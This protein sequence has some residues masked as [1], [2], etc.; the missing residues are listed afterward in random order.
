M[1]ISA[2]AIL[3][4]GTTCLGVILLI[5]CV[6]CLTIQRCSENPGPPP[7]A[8]PRHRFTR[9]PASHI[10]QAY[11]ASMIAVDGADVGDT[12]AICLGELCEDVEG[13]LDRAK[14][15]RVGLDSVVIEDGSGTS[16]A[17]PGA[18]DASPI[19]CASSTGVRN[20]IKGVQPADDPAAVV[21]G[22]GPRRG[23][24]AQPLHFFRGAHS[25]TSG[26]HAPP[27]L[28]RP[29]AGA[30]ALPSMSVSV[31]EREVAV[32]IASGPRLVSLRCGHVYHGV[33]VRAWI[34]HRRHGVACPLC[35]CELLA[36][37]WQGERVARDREREGGAEAAEEREQRAAHDGEHQWV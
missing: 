27:R 7:P 17:A 3:V 16:P 36:K 12:C 18:G 5:S 30:V 4:I 21:A 1:N 11:N 35:K 2:L 20:E 34:V 14:G 10:L 26:R 31:A 8:I 22:V 23:S 15:Q 25:A 9:T 37:A 32:V 13:R 28:G 6:I 19:L 24:A 33:C 29:A